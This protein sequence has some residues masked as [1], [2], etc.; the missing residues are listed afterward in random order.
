MSLSKLLPILGIVLGSVCWATPIQYR[1]AGTAS[2]A[3]GV[4]GFSDVAITILVL[5]DTA[6]VT[7]G[8]FLNPSLGTLVEVPGLRS[9]T[10]SDVTQMFSNASSGF[11]GIGDVTLNLGLFHIS[12]PDSYDLAGNFG[13]VL[14]SSVGVSTFQNIGTDQGPLSINSLSNVT[15]TA[16]LTGVPEP[17]TLSSMLA[18]AVLIALRRRLHLLP[19]A[20]R[21]RLSDPYQPRTALPE[22]NVRSS[23][24]SRTIRGSLLS[25]TP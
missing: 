17:C 7:S 10:L 20:L 13:P 1:F 25:A 12:T 14:D 15:F 5:G 9:A 8:P 22:N 21:R 24:A 19:S 23:S 6:N 18:G 2:G 3:L 4:S 11:L 16:T